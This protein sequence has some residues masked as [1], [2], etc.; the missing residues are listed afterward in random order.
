MAFCDFNLEMAARRLGLTIS[1]RADLFA[2]MKA[3]EVSLILLTL[4]ERWATQALEVN[5][6]KARSEMII[7]PILMEAHAPDG[8]SAGRLL[9]R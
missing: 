6:E 5:A 4:L 2:G 7:S 9:R 1:A 3:L 8:R